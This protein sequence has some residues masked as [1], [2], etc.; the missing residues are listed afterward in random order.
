MLHGITN[1][2]NIDLPMIWPKN[3]VLHIIDAN[4]YYSPSLISDYHFI[5]PIK[6]PMKKWKIPNIQRIYT[7]LC[8]GPPIFM[9]KNQVFTI[10]YYSICKLLWFQPF[11]LLA[12]HMKDNVVPVTLNFGRYFV[13]VY[14]HFINKSWQRWKLYVKNKQNLMNKSCGPIRSKILQTNIA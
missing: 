12:A 11:I 1:C 14:T 7:K 4:R 9:H 10:I 2:K 3:I 8:I 13:H 5:N 6:N